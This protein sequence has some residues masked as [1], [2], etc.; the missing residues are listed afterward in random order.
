MEDAPLF[1]LPSPIYHFP[2]QSGIPQR[3]ARYSKRLPD[4]VEQPVLYT[5]PFRR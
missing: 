4:A 3:P 1:H 2:F 5:S